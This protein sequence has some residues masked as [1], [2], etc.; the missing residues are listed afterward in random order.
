MMC[1]LMQASGL[2]RIG[3]F[4]SFY[5]TGMALQAAPLLVIHEFDGR[6]RPL[7]SHAAVCF[8]CASA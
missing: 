2:E 5:L 6:C 1:L 3:L 8:V 4:V 7:H